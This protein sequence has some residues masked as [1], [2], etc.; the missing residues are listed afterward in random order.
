MKITSCIVAMDCHILRSFGPNKA[1]DDLVKSLGRED[2]MLEPHLWDE[3]D[4]QK[5]GTPDEAPC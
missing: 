5:P 1:V 4:D 2:S 3:R